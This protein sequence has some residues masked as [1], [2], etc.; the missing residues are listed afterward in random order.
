[1]ISVRSRKII[2]TYDELLENCKQNFEPKYKAEFDKQ[3]QLIY[4]M[5]RENVIATINSEI[6]EAKTTPPRDS[7][8]CFLKS[9]FPTVFIR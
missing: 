7:M 4:Q 5:L 9:V 1:M 6:K 8:R 2:P 3:Y